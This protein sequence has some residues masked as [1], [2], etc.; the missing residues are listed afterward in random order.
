MGLYKV[1]IKGIEGLYRG[2]VQRKDQVKL[3]LRSALK[4]RQCL[5][6]NL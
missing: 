6:A 5:H 2:E 4:P 1:Y 3:S